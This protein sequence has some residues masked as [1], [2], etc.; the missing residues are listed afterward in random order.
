MIGVSRH[1]TPLLWR[2][3]VQPLDPLRLLGVEASVFPLGKLIASEQSLSRTPVGRSHLSM[4]DT[5]NAR[6]LVL[7]LKAVAAA[8]TAAT[9]VVKTTKP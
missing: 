1:L 5:M 3:Y 6:T 4:E 9:V 8:L 2:S 7:T